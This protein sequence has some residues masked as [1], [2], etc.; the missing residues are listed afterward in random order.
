L[1][2]AVF[3]LI[4][5]ALT[6]A[7]LI[8]PSQ[9]PPQ[10]GA[11]AAVDLPSVAVCPVDEGS[12]RNTTIGIASGINGEGRFTAFAGGVSAGSSEFSTGASG[13]VAIPLADVAPV[14]TSA[15]LAELPGPDV[16]AASLLLS[17]ETVA[18]ETCVA[19]PIQQTLLAGGST[20]SGEE[21]QVQL[22]N[23]YAGEAVVDLIV[24]SESGLESIPQLRGISVPSRSSVRTD[25]SELLPGRESLAIT[26]QVVSGSVMAAAR[27]GVGTD[28][29]LWH[30]VAPALDWYV[31]V[32]AAGIGG[33]IV[34]STGVG[35]DVAFQVDVHGPQGLVE[36]FL[37]GVVPARG[38]T[39]VPLADLGLEAASAVRVISTQPVGVFLRSVAETGVAITSGSPVSAARWLLPG[40]GLAPGSTGSAVVL[41]AG[42]EEA[43]V[44]VT[45]LRDQSVANEYAVPAGTVLEVPAVE[46][47]ANAYT[48]KGEG[49]LV[50]MWVTTTPTGSAYSIGVPLLDE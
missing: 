46:G 37:D 5:A 44:V 2:K 48:V 33:E 8:V 29:A 14:G 16:A 32:P 27:F 35:A 38:T 25:L 11:V 23:P 42:L 36:A 22:M 43:T 41:N 50:P 13:S 12:G 18:V 24:Y 20:I 26:V 15:G 1:I 21:H 7:V 49:S 17:A 9:A 34:I 4:V 28:V 45:A 30:S 39:V 47:G 10:S 3:A 19:T 6:A 31:P 40:A